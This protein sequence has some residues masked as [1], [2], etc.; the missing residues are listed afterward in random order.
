MALP[1][2]LA[3][4][5]TGLSLYGQYKQGKISAAMGRLRQQYANKA[6]QETVAAGQRAALEERRNAEILASRAIAVAAAGGRSGDA[7]AAKIVTDIQGEGAY[8]A[9]VAMYDAEE[10]AKKIKF[11]GNMAAYQGEQDAQNARLGMLGTAL[12][13]GAS[14]YSQFNKPKKYGHVTND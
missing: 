4:A 2:I 14:M 8:R 12:S 13:G 6:A 7:S 11:E 9:A 1:L 10:Q 3:A 5:G